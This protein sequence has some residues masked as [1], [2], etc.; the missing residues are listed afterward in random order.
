MP[1]KSIALLM[2]YRTLAWHVRED[3]KT[4]EM[5]AILLEWVQKLQ[6]EMARS[7]ISLS[8]EHMVHVGT[9]ATANKM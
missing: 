5:D 4:P 2:P 7:G 1:E 8:D 3:S 9:L 6:E